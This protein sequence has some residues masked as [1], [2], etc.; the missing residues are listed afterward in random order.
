VR[1]QLEITATTR[2]ERLAWT[3]VWAA[4]GLFLLSVVSV[5]LGVRWY[6]SNAASARPARVEAIRGTVLLKPAGSRQE[7]SAPARFDLVEGDQIRTTADSQALV[8]LVDGSTVRLWGD[9]SLRLVRNTST[10]FN[11][12]RTDIMLEHLTGK[13][14]VEVALLS[15]LART[16]QVLTPQSTVWLREG[17]YGIQV[18]DAETDVSV[19]LGSASVSGQDRTI[20]LLRGERTVVRTGDSP[21]GQIP[22]AQDFVTNGD[23]AQALASWQAANR[24]VEDGINGDVSIIQQDGRHIVRFQRRGTSRHGET[25]IHQSIDRDVTDL[26]TLDLGLEVKLLHQSLSGGGW[27]GSEYPLA[28]KLRYRDSVGNELTW[29]RGFYLSNEENRPVPNGVLVPGDIWLAYSADLFSPSQVSPRPAHIL[30]V[31]IESSGWEY[32]S[33]VTSIQLTG[34]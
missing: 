31:E 17:S 9:S 29:T 20:E 1:Y 23:F 27:V 7:I 26:Q 33:M 24:N 22:S 6:V 15:T 10:R 12:N 16:F 13:L 30:W 11:T 32:E 19:R 14:R 18:S 25:F 2:R 8:S 3:I 34:D 28:L 4:L 21:I 5:P